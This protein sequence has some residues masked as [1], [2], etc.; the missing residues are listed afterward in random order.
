MVIDYCTLNIQS[1]MIHFCVRS[2]TLIKMIYHSFL[3][4]KCTI[5]YINIS[6]LSLRSFLT[7]LSMHTHRVI[8]KNE[9]I[10]GFI[11]T[12]TDNCILCLDGYSVSV[13][14]IVN[15]AENTIQPQ[16]LYLITIII[17]LWLKSRILTFSYAPGSI[18]LFSRTEIIRLKSSFSREKIHLYCHRH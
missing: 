4:N 8:I 16:S 5:N 15:K 3:H 14:E 1:C 11:Q 6:T 17:S 7:Q 9:H 10:S 12:K 18:L 13:Q 2:N